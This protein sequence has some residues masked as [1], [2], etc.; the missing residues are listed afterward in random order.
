MELLGDDDFGETKYEQLPPEI[1]IFCREVQVEAAASASRL[2]DTWYRRPAATHRDY[3]LEVTALGSLVSLE[4]YCVAVSLD[5]ASEAD[6]ST[7]AH[8]QSV[9]EPPLTNVK[10]SLPFSAD[11]LIAL[12]STLRGWDMKAGRW[13]TQPFAEDRELLTWWHGFLRDTEL[14]AQCQP[15]ST[16]AL[17]VHDACVTL[18]R[19]LC[20]LV[21]RTRDWGLY[22]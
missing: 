20:A 12:R 19:G 17:A 14:N 13:Q 4:R 9:V 22:Q 1:E 2:A 3:A 7:P 16:E 15:V 6:I 21:G 8:V 18:Y 10:H 11:Q 5:D